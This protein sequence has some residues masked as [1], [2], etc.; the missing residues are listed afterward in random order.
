MGL[1]TPPVNPKIVPDSSYFDAAREAGVNPATSLTTLTGPCRFHLTKCM[2]DHILHYFGSKAIPADVQLDMCLHSEKQS[3]LNPV[4]CMVSSQ[5]FAQNPLS[6][7][8]ATSSNTHLSY[9]VHG[10]PIIVL[11]H[12][13]HA[14]YSPP[15]A[16]QVDYAVN[17]AGH[18]ILSEKQADQKLLENR[19]GNFK[20]RS[21]KSGR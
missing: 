19:M 16:S 13:G 6:Y 5:L 3:R 21:R 10:L 15:S 8:L 9:R 14:V 2:R 20:R 17:T 11:N 12:E 4:E 1:Q 18:L 7:I